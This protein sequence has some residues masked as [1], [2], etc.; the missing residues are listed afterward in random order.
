MREQKKM[1]DKWRER[2]HGNRKNKQ[3][4]VLKD[5]REAWRRNKNQKKQS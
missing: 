1:K 3:E 4:E 2:E 5:K